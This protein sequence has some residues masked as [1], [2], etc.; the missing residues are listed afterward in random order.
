ML[1]ED[2]VDGDV[3]LLRVERSLSMMCSGFHHIRVFLPPV[4]APVTAVTV[5]TA[6]VR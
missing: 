5:Y 6:P 2:L 1:R 3:N 4:T